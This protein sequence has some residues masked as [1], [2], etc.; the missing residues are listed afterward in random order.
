MKTKALF[1]L[2]PLILTAL[3]GCGG[4]EDTPT[5][6]STSSSSSTSVIPPSSTTSTSTTPAPEGKKYTIT[7]NNWDGTLLEKDENVPEGS[8]PNYN[9]TTPTRP[10]DSTYSYTFKGWDPALA[11]VTQNQTYTATYDRTVLTYTID[12]D[13][14]GG[15]SASYDGPK[16]VEAFSDEYF[17][18]DVVKEDWNFRGWSYNNERIFDEKGHQLANPVMA[19]HMVFKA[20]FSQTVKLTVIKNIASAG[21]ATGEGEYPYN[22]NVNL[23]AE[24]VEGYVFGGWY[25]DDI[26]I[27]STKKYNFKMWSKDVTV[28]ARFF[29]MVHTLTVKSNNVTKGT[30]MIQNDA[31]AGYGKEETQYI[32]AQSQVTIAAN[33]LT[34]TRF[35]GWYDEDGNLIDTNAIYKFVMPNEDLTLYAK[36]NPVTI[37]IN[38]SA[39]PDYYTLEDDVITLKNPSRDNYYFNHWLIKIEDYDMEATPAAGFYAASM[40]NYVVTAAWIRGEHNFSVQSSNDANGDVELEAGTGLEGETM[41]VRAYP[42]DNALFKGWWADDVRVSTDLTYEFIMPNHNVS[43]VAQFV[44]KYEIGFLTRKV[45]SN[46]FTSGL[47]PQSKVTDVELANKLDMHSI[48]D[49]EYRY[50]D[51]NYYEYAMGKWFKCEP[52]EW[53]KLA[54]ERFITSKILDARVYYH[55][56]SDKPLPCDYKASD[57]RG[58]LDDSMYARM[59]A[60]NPIL[61]TRVE[62]RS[63]TTDSEDNPYCDKYSDPIYQKLYLPSYADM[64]NGNY[65]FPSITGNST[66]R[67]ASPT[68]YA[69]EAGNSGTS[70]YYWT[71]SPYSK[72]DAKQVNCVDGNGAMQQMSVASKLGIRPMAYITIS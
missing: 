20:I 26:L 58:Y 45:S 4:G 28:E 38:K 32:S 17:F 53:I 52:V 30:V 37:E 1:T 11:A 12:F 48:A 51:C 18:F 63:S 55:S 64:V 22:S 8:A 67:K 66:A 46:K 71:R 41:R 2:L 65:G 36:W 3:T 34:K 50:Y 10:D 42:E 25:V 39:N 21:T 62:N 16:T 40:E 56:L 59:F 35:L 7:W 44:N 60:M 6:E 33:T 57:I 23:V 27:A 13:L 47:Y 19:K 9:G 49:G 31:S 69:I 24:A 43:L 70:S 29:N 72:G 14:Q 15:T 68:E 54:N 61:D 5:S